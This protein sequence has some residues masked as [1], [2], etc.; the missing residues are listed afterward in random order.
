MTETKLAYKTVTNAGQN[1]RQP[2][3]AQRRA[4][5]FFYSQILQELKDQ[6]LEFM[7]DGFSAQLINEKTK[8]LVDDLIANIGNIRL[9]R[10]NSVRFFIEHEDL[11]ESITAILGELPQKDR[12]NDLLNSTDMT[13]K[14]SIVLT[15]RPPGA[16]QMGDRRLT[17]DPVTTSIIMDVL[18]RWLAFA[19]ERQE[20]LEGIL[21]GLEEIEVTDLEQYSCLPDTIRDISLNIGT[22]GDLRGIIE[23][24]MNKLLSWKELKPTA[25]RWFW[26]KVI[27]QGVELINTYCHDGECLPDCPKI[28]DLAL[29]TTA[30]ILCLIY[31]DHFPDS[32]DAVAAQIKERYFEIRYPQN[33]GDAFIRNLFSHHLDEETKLI[34]RSHH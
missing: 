8:R 15:L 33:E 32:P 4:E 14:Y 20:I 22:Y 16:E 11:F 13:R 21:A 34:D 6:F 23:D 29:E 27:V 1:P 17:Q 24:I 10:L 28:H 9:D 26:E 12:I 7:N 25:K 31:P 5:K 18:T 3:R 2:L 30:G 19:R